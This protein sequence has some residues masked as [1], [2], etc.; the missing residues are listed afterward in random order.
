MQLTYTSP[1]TRLWTDDFSRSTFDTF[2]ETILVPADRVVI[3]YNRAQVYIF[4]NGSELDAVWQE[5]FINGH[6]CGGELACPVDMLEHFN[7]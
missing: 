3:E 7:K 5:T 6:I 1:G 2:Y 4:Q